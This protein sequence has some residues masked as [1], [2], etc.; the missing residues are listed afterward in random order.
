MALTGFGTVVR[1][2]VNLKKPVTDGREIP[3]HVLW[4]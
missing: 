4:K 3:R 2:V 1:E